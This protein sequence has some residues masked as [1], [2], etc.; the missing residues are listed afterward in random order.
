MSTFH[1][2]E[3]LQSKYEELQKLYDIS[4]K[5]IS[6]L[7]Q[8]LLLETH[9]IHKLQWENE[10]ED[11]EDEQ[12]KIEINLDDIEH[13]IETLKRA[14]GG[15]SLYDAL[16]RLDYR[17]QAKAFKQFFEE[18]H[19]VGAFLI[20]GKSEYGQRWLLNRLL[21]AHHSK[22]VAHGS[23]KVIQVD[24]QRRA[25]RVSIDTLWRELA[26]QVGLTDLRSTREVIERVQTW[27]Q[28]QTVVFV[29]HNLHVMYE[30]YVKEFIQ[31][32]WF[33]LA[34]VA[35]KVP[36]QSS[37]Y[38]LMF[39][40]DHADCIDTW[41]AA[42]TELHE[43]AEFHALIKFQKLTPFSIE[44]LTEWIEYEVDTLPPDLNAQIILEGNN[45]SPDL[46]LKRIC[47]LC[48]CDWYE[49]ESIWM[50]F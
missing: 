28:T 6:R 43:V 44:V 21:V 25:R 2:L 47:N 50:K 20:H 16:L 18:K 13:R 17:E 23:L 15:D 11:A 37:N 8:K 27:W 14:L 46:V 26:H 42:F 32:L 19:Q 40:V 49:R 45:N 1:Q 3:R 12:S 22:L 36:Y 34:D 38:Y 7:K 48:G 5:K 33:P 24:L 41:S 29:F 31:K 4:S 10:I 9:P 39:L 35:Q 30:D